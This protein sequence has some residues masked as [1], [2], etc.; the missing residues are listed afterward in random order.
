[1]I[2]HLIRAFIGYRLP[3]KTPPLW[4]DRSHGEWRTEKI[5]SQKSW[6]KD[7]GDG[8]GTMHCVAVLGPPSRWVNPARSW[9]QRL[10]NYRTL[11]DETTRWF[12]TVWKPAQPMAAIVTRRN[13]PPPTEVTNLS[14]CCYY[15]LTW[16]GFV[17]DS[18][19][20]VYPLKCSA[21]GKPHCAQFPNGVKPGW[22]PCSK[23]AG[24]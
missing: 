8:T 7:H 12:G 21:C 10:E 2:K 11:R 3:S 17:Y 19:P 6:N 23:S 22:M 24:M 9:K 18:D 14:E 16:C 15:P 5:Q 4:L 1:M 13:G 20:G